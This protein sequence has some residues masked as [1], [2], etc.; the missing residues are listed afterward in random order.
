MVKEHVL[1]AFELQFGPCPSLDHGESKEGL[2]HVPK[3]MVVN[4]LQDWPSSAPEARWL[5]WKG[6][7]LPILFSNIQPDQKPYDI[8]DGK[9][10]F[11]LDWLTECF[12]W[13]TG[14]SEILYAPKDIFGRICYKGSLVEKL[15]LIQMPVV[16]LWFD[17]FREALKEIGINSNSKWG[18]SI[19]I[20]HDIDLIHSG[21]KEDAFFALKTGRILSALKTIWH[22]LHGGYWNNLEEMA[23]NL[24]KQG[25][26]STFF[27]ITEQG[28]QG[29][30]KNAD[31]SLS[32]VKEVWPTLIGMGS[33]VGLHATNEA[34]KNEAS[35]S[36]QKGKM[37]ESILGMRYHY[38]RFDPLE[39]PGLI[40][41]NGFSYDSTVGFAEH[42]G[43]R[44]LCC[45]PY[46]LFDWK[47][48]RSTDVI[49]FPLVVMDRTLAG[50]NYMALE[51]E[52]AQRLVK[53]LVS[54]WNFLN[55]VMSLLWHNN[56]FTHLK[57]GKWAKCF[58]NLLPQLQ[59]EAVLGNHAGFLKKFL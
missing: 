32:E 5:S 11:N 23:T 20:S 6:Y 41:N 2:I 55:P 12:F 7:E 4:N 42:V 56:Y 36:A 14:V 17:V 29:S 13:L 38:L 31:Y 46:F 34:H 18:S 1:K 37:P 50:K 10:V 24:R 48:G 19:L 26:S 59:S 3:S 53:D 51:P 28:Q 21:W 30:I 44:S 8:E 49:E 25:V 39:T 45:T 57:Y 33:E 16:N 40:Q 43:F 27:F 58:W 52:G 54:E 35:L 22:G 9:V 15:G 47:K